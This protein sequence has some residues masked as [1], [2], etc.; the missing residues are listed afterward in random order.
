M[1]SLRWRRIDEL[2]SRARALDGPERERFLDEACAGDAALHT[3]LVSLLAASADDGFL[4]SPAIDLAAGKLDAPVADVGVRSSSE[5]VPPGE[6][7][8]H[9][10]VM[11]HLGEGGMGVVYEAEDEHLGRRVALKVLRED[12]TDP[13]GRERLVREARVAAGIAHPQICQVFDL[14]EWRERPFIA[15]ELVEGEPL[16]ARLARGPLPPREALRIALGIAEALGVLHRHGIVHRD[17]KPSNIFLTARGIKVLDFGLARPMLLEA[18][19]TRAPVTRVGMF[20]GTPQYAAPEHLLGMPIDARADLFSA[21]V[22]LFEMLAGRPPFSG[23]TLAALAHA[24]IYEAPPVLTGS[25]GAAAIDRLLHRALAKAREDR[26]PTTEAF[27]AELR[28]AMALAEGAPTIE[29]RPILR[30]AVLPFRLLK[31]DPTL[32]YL[33]LGLADALAGSLMGLESLVVRSIL[34]SARYTRAQAD[35]EAIASELAVDLVLTGSLLCRKGQVR[36]TAELVSVPAG[37]VWWSRIVD[38]AQDAVLDLHDEL[39][40]LVVGSLPLTASDQARAPRREIGRK[41]FDLYL[42]GM[43]LRS[44]ATGWRQ[45]RA[46]FE[47][48]LQVDPSFAAAWAERGR[49]D[50]ILGKYEDP[51][52]L[53]RAES[54]LLHALDLDPACGAAQYYLAQLEVDLGRLEDALARL[55]DRV[56]QHRAEPHVYAALVHGCRYAGLLGESVAAHGLARRLDPTIHTSVL[57]TYYMQGDLARV[58]EEAHQSSDPIEA[59]ALGALGRESEAI[60][61]ARR[62]EA[63]FASVP[64]L[65]AFSTGLRA[66]FEGRPDEAL[67]ALEPFETQGFRDGEGLFYVAEI[68]A[69]LNDADRALRFLDRAVDAGFVCLPG[70]ERDVYLAPLRG[71]AA[72]NV[73]IEHLAA[74]QRDVAEGFER[75]GGRSLFRLT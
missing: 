37:D 8:A 72:W 13:A 74:R 66:A 49:L 23:A 34:K 14:G 11:R 28:G 57:H 39:A 71:T 73:R 1:D 6:R 45:A 21:G 22:I 5:R 33:E 18:D 30:L 60:A 12:S 32:E 25:P 26:Y 52:R 48:S 64:R 29:A 62:E 16:A 58:V 51:E 9:Y 59:R 61:A 19:A 70:F 65:R 40:R 36:V 55:L 46:F 54:A 69:R 68:Y 35:L 24:V 53:A 17:L 15:M 2:F 47:Q 41:A 3:E 20:A 56:H 43:Q 10:R 4:S 31:P 42:R 63:R 44:E 7:I 75:R 27:A 50:G 38:A 67:A